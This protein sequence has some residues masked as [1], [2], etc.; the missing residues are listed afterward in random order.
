MKRVGW[1]FAAML[2]G[3]LALSA[4]L[5]GSAVAGD[6]AVQ[7]GPGG[8][9][10]RLQC[11]N[12]F[13]MLGV[14]MHTGA[15]VDAIRANCMAFNAAA[16]NWVRPPQFTGFTGGNGG[17]PQPQQ[18]GCPEGTYMSGI[19]I[20]F[21]RS[22][23]RPQYLKYVQMNC[24]P[25]SGYGGAAPVCLQTGNGCWDAAGLSFSI[26]CPPGQ[27]AIGLVGRSGVYIDA[28]GLICGPRPAAAAG[29]VATAPP[30]T[31]PGAVPPEWSDM[32]AAHNERRNLHCAPALTWSSQLAADAQRW[33][34]KCTNSHEQGT[35]E[36]ENL[37]FFY[38]AG[39]RDRVA[40]ENSWY[41]EVNNYNFDHPQVVGGFKNGC[42]P[43]VNGHFTQVV[44][45]ASRQ[46]GCG[47]KTCTINGQQ[48]TY[49]VCRY[50]PPGNFNANDPNV[51]AQNVLRPRPNCQ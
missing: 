36:G 4:A 10:F 34:D 43:P 22:D 46:L 42:D 21:T 8:G 49:W 45:K 27:A 12:N 47:K 29:P 39:Q 25:L 24:P 35:S 40:F 9:A 13:F 11:P 31:V 19:K 23:N 17:N 33:A 5:S 44:W 7:G 51:L 15:W 50:S 6:T 30:A 1:K 32:L 38:P 3:S 2:A 48:G 28:L 26:D 18:N 37:A 16:Q 41:C 20:G 14:A